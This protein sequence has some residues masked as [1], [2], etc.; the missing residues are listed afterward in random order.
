MTKQT[1]CFPSVVALGFRARSNFR[2]GT[3]PGKVDS[4]GLQGPNRWA[5]SGASS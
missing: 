5:R 2:V 4:E 1:M 3:M